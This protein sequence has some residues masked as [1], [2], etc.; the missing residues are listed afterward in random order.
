MDEDQS[1]GDK[2]HDATPRKLEEARNKGEIVRS[3]DLNTAIIYI[4]FLASAALLAPWATQNIGTEFQILLGEADRIAPLMLAPGGT[5][6]AGGMIGTAVST[7]GALIAVPASLLLLYL[8]AQRAILF[9]PSKL[10]PKLSRISVI[11]NAKQKFGSQGIFQF[12]KSA[13]KLLIVAILLSA[14]L[15]AR[16]EVIIA[17]IYAD[18]GQ[19]LAALGR[20]TFDFMVVVALVAA[21]IGGVDWFWETAQHHRKNRMSRQELI[22][23]GKN[24]EGDPHMKQQRRQRGQSIAMNQMLGDVPGADVVIVNPTHY[25]VALQWDRLSGGVPVCVAKGVD[26]VARRIREAAA[27]GA[28]PIFSDPPTARALHAT[29]E[30]G[31]AIPPDQFKAVAA[32][33]RFADIMRQKA[34]KKRT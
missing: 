8:I 23:E 21:A 14:Y 19:V 25:A 30:I 2:P 13:F 7:L 32:A 34:R 16:A 18:A 28:V 20:L 11:S 3:A 22:D 17:S 4:G 1:P 31:D 24:S 27:E 12:A 6:T 9:S 15:F 29:I 33:I 5:A 26:D 10:E